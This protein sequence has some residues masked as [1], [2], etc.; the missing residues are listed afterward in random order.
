M[1]GGQMFGIKESQIVVG[2]GAAELTTVT[3]VLSGNLVYMDQLSRIHI[4]IENIDL[5]VPSA[6]GFK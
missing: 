6:E 2:N 5:S 3:T 4:K 1:L